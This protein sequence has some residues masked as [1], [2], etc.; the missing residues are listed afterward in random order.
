MHLQVLSAGQAGITA[1]LG[2]VFHAACALRLG[3][4]NYAADPGWTGQCVGGAQ[5]PEIAETSLFL[6]NV[7]QY[8]AVKCLDMHEWRKQKI[9]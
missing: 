3:S 7:R 5:R 9:E 1:E 6:F 8:G 2:R 4:L